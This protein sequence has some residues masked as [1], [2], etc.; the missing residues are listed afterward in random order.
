MI[1][2]DKGRDKHKGKRPKLTFKELLA[3]YVKERDIK[4]ARRPN[5]VKQ[6]WSP[7]NCKYG[8]WNWREKE[9]PTTVPYPYFGLPMLMSCGPSPNGFHSYS[10]WR[11]DGSWAHPP[12]Y[13][14]PYNQRCIAQRKQM[15]ERPYIKDRFQ[16]D[17]RSGAQEKK[18]VVKQ[19][20]RVKRDGRRDKSSDLSSS[21][22][23]LNNVVKISATSGKKIANISKYFAE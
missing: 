11:S 7:P 1:K 6:S 8:D 23:K 18:K 13:Y 19:V 4:S 22:E 20:Y 14:G 15:F 16:R 17:N 3:K 5:K 21:D 2:E 10:S 12:S 9:V